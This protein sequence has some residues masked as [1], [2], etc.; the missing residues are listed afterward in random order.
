MIHR[1][2]FFLLLMAGIVFVPHQLVAQ[3]K[4]DPKKTKVDPKKKVDLSSFYR[5]MS[6]L[7]PEDQIKA[8]GDKMR[9]SNPGFK[10]F[11]YAK[12]EGGVVAR[13]GVDATYV[14]DV[15]PLRAFAGLKELSASA[16]TY[17][18]GKITDLTSLAGLKLE[19]LDLVYNADLTDISVVKG[20][21][22]K[23][24]R[25]DHTKIASIE[26][27]EGC[28]TLETLKCNSTRV[29][30][31]KPLKGLTLK[32]LECSMCRGEK[33]DT[34]SDL[35]PLAGMKLE[36]FYCDKISAKDFSVLKPMPIAELS[37]GDNLQIT[38]FT[39]LKDM[40]LKE[41]YLTRTR[42]TEKD[43]LILKGKPIRTLYLYGTPIKDLLF[44]K[45]LPLDLLVCSA[46]TQ[47]KDLHPLKGMKIKTFYC[48]ET[49]IK[50]LG[51]LEGMPLTSLYCQDTSISS[52]E[53]LKGMPLDILWCGW[54]NR[55]G[56][57]PLTDLS[58]LAGT[59]IRT[60]YCEN[61]SIK[62]LKPLSSMKVVVLRCDNTPIKDLKPLAGTP[63]VELWCQGTSVVDF[64][65]LK[66]AEKLS[67]LKCDYKLPKDAAALRSIKS[68]RML[69][70]LNA[71]NLLN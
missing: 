36:R 52:L 68:L 14:V 64:A 6:A 50:D 10:D 71:Q 42:F 47:L 48:G 46:C 25:C 8:V 37:V 32:G 44:V 55:K 5:V 19:H 38:D 56:R 21:P 28:T 16:A 22:I 51:P 33:G 9:D 45:D 60:L 26:P 24:L 41:L 17:M 70:G 61:T 57:S 59:P 66:D 29:T 58:P 65:P 62:D 7:K 54:R 11:S 35:S 27:L 43:G 69:N 23:F 34:V 40:P 53:P 39:I 3:G 13:V 49:P 63:V 31:L 18:G 4:V 1:I 2:T 30:N 15:A 12:I 20:M 67:T